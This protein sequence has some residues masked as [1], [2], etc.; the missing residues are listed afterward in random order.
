M[1][2]LGPTVSGSIVKPVAFPLYEAL[3]TQ[4]V[5]GPHSGLRASGR[6]ACVRPLAA[7]ESVATFSEWVEPYF[8]TPPS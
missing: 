1:Y 7:T 5:T 8:V 2:A 3:V 4:I 6:A